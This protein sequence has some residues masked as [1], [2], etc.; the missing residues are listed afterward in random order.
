[1]D[2]RLPVS[3]LLSVCPS[4][5]PSTTI[6]H[7]HPHTRAA[8]SPKELWGGGSGRGRDGNAL[9]TVRSAAHVSSTLLRELSWCSRRFFVS[10]LYGV[11]AGAGTES[12]QGGGGQRWSEEHQGKIGTAMVGSSGRTSLGHEKA[13]S[14]QAGGGGG[15]QG[16]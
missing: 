1:M 15:G 14:R 6:N 10:S 7:R 13:M 8:T 12:W 11:G 4:G 3:A 16:A 2:G 5:T 9:R